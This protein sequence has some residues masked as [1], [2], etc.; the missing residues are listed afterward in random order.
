MK[1]KAWVVQ[2][3][4]TRDKVSPGRVTHFLAQIESLNA[5]KSYDSVTGWYVSKHGF[6]KDATRMLQE[7]NILFSD[8]EGFNKL[9]KLVGFFGWPE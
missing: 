4:N 2:V 8:R 7:A 6:T 9:A 5:S 1:K 3:K